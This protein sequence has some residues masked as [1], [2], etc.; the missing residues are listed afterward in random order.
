MNGSEEFTPIFFHK[1]CKWIRQNLKETVLK[2][3]ITWPTLGK[4][5]MQAKEVYYHWRIQI[6]TR[7]SR[8]WYWS[9][10]VIIGPSIELDI[11]STEYLGN[12]KTWNYT[13]TICKDGRIQEMQKSSYKN[14]LYSY[15]TFLLLVHV[16]ENNNV[17][18]GQARVL[19]VSLLYWRISTLIIYSSFLGV[20]NVRSVS[21]A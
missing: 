6:F 3:I 7:Y 21:R 2:R 12:L 8:Y 5:N 20:K 19:T 10:D 18:G 15:L 9:L 17:E 13:P 4:Q 16:D 1:L 14:T 11:M